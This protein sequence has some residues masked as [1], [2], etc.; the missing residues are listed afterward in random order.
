MRGW[1]HGA[2]T[3]GQLADNWTV[4]P[5]GTRFGLIQQDTLAFHTLGVIEV[6]GHVRVSQCAE[7]M[8]WQIPHSS[9]ASRIG[10]G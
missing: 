7:R 8:S 9:L 3:S 5:I 4:Q 2:G 1:W 10:P 6:G